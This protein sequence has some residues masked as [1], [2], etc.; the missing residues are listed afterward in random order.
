MET[1]IVENRRLSYM[2]VVVYL[3]DW[4]PLSLMVD[5]SVYGCLKDTTKSTTGHL[6]DSK[7]E[8]VGKSFHVTQCSQNK[9]TLLLYC[10]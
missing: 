2:I 9:G 8:E 6:K 5:Y 1:I 4:F 3:A 7:V 10:M